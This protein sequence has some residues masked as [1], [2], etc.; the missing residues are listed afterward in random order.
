M[1]IRHYTGAY[2]K[3]NSTS[4]IFNKAHTY[5]S[6]NGAMTD[7]WTDGRLYAAAQMNAVRVS[8][9]P[10]IAPILAENGFTRT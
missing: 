4:T 6:S 9:R 1:D 8:V 10:S 3:I 5:M 2:F 7:R